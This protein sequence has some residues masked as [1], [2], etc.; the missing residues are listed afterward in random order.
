MS[1]ELFDVAKALGIN[2]S[3]VPSGK[4]EYTGDVDEEAFIKIMN[5][6]IFESDV[7]C[8]A[9][10]CRVMWFKSESIR[11]SGKPFAVTISLVGLRYTKESAEEKKLDRAADIV[12][13]ANKRAWAEAMMA[14]DKLA[15]RIEKL[16]GAEGP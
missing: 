9:V 3:P 6:Y 5:S 4:R 11:D 14:I 10:I 7:V 16:E 1:T 8:G 12:V 2:I 13:R 15:D